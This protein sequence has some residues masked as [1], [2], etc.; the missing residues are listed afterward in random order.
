MIRSRSK[1]VLLVAPKAFPSELVA[2][3]NAVRQVSVQSAIFPSIH[4]V[5]PDVILFDYEHM[6]DDM[7]KILRRLQSNSYYRNIK[8]CCYKNK[9]HT[10]VDGLLKVLGVNHFFYQEDLEKTSKSKS[11]LSAIN[12]IL[13]ASI[14]NWVA[15]VA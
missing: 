12:G 7:E 11:A 13:D 8:I 9:E 6:A 15:G 5:K 4:E 14:L 1:K 2:G 10:R 3:Y